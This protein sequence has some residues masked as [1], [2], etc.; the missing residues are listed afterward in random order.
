MELRVEEEQFESR[1]GVEGQDEVVVLIGESLEQRDEQ[2][3][4]RELENWEGLDQTNE[5]Q[6]KRD[7]NHRADEGE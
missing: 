4:E 1:P 3:G 7:A 6:E 5:S 2:D